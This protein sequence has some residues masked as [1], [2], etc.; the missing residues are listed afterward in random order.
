[1][2]W[3]S[4]NCDMAVQYKEMEILIEAKNIQ[5]RWKQKKIRKQ[6]FL[7]EGQSG[8]NPHQIGI[9]IVNRREHLL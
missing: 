7:H 3:W 8:K 5:C 4:S 6:L 9:I 2:I 1:M